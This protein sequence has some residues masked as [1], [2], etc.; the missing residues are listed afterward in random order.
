MSRRPLDYE[1]R[2]PPD[3]ADDEPLW[4]QL[5]GRAAMALLG[6]II[7]GMGALLVLGLHPVLVI[8][9]AVVILTGAM[10]VA[11][12]LL[13]R[14]WSEPAADALGSVGTSLGRLLEGWWWW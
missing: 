9:G 6:G 8:T 11:G 1:R 4:R 13:P 3:P 7:C 2:P 12:G 14:R 5:V 10:F